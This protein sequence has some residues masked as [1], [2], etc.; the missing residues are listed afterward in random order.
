[1]IAYH[2][3]PA[4]DAEVRAIAIETEKRDIEAGYVP[5][6]WKCTCGAQHGR[7]YFPPGAIGSHRCLH[8]G[9]VGYHGVMWDPACDPEPFDLDVQPS[10]APLA[11]VS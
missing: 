4:V 1:M 3:D 9:E 7:G 11:G 2:P 5:R 10:P 6:R 8:C